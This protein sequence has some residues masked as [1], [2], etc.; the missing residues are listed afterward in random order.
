MLVDIEFFILQFEVCLFVF[1]GKI[2]RAQ[3]APKHKT[4]NFHPLRS[5]RERKKLLSLLFSVSLFLF[6]WLIFGVDVLFCARDLFVKKK[7]IT[8]RLEIVLITSL[9]YTAVMYFTMLLLIF[10][11]SLRGKP[12]DYKIVDGK[13]LTTTLRNQ[14]DRFMTIFSNF[15]NPGITSHSKTKALRY[16]RL[17]SSAH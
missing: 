5:F 16:F 12:N 15:F 2:S 1:Y 6:C 8:N 9:F 11:L 4:I 3:K 14:L 10:T 13:N 7:I 17:K